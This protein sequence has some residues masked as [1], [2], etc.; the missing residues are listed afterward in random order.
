MHILVIDDEPQIRAVARRVLEREG[1][2]V[3]E[4]ADGREAIALI[5]SQ[6]FHVVLTDVYMPNVDGISLLRHLRKAGGS[7]R[8]VAMSGAAFAG[9]T[10]LLETAK[11][12][13]ASQV[14]PKPFTPDQ[15]LA[16][17]RDVTAG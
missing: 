11:R 15:L 16:A 10:D 6:A 7:M 13:G 14:L 12:L 2:T 1:H 3:V 9:G 17:I 5:E 4:A 8:I